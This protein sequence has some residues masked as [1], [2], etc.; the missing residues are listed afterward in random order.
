MLN[1]F[2]YSMLDQMGPRDWNKKFMTKF[3]KTYKSHPCLW[4]VGC[5]QYSDSKLRVKAYQQLVH[6]CKTIYKNANK[7][8]VIQ[9]ID[10]IRGCYQKEFEKVQKS[11]RITSKGYTYVSKLWYYDLLSFI[12]N[13]QT[14]VEMVEDLQVIDDNL[15]A[16]E[17]SKSDVVNVVS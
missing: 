6:L 10:F 3:I 16:D 11:K 4:K 13:E 12:K 14:V 8:F 15:S 1:L 2:V 17:N 5:V 9:K 7:R